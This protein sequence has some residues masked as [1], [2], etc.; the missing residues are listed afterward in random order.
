MKILMIQYK[1]LSYH[2]NPMMSTI[3]NV[4]CESVGVNKL[5]PLFEDNQL[6]LCSHAFRNFVYSSNL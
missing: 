4:F 3:I 6:F 1:T 5:L 2:I